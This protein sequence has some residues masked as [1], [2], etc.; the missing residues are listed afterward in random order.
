MRVGGATSQLEYYLSLV[1]ISISFL[2]QS[3]NFSVTLFPCASVL[4]CTRAK[5]FPGPLQSNTASGLVQPSRHHGDGI[6]QS[7]MGG[8]H[9]II[10][11]N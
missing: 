3:N 10:P 9:L 2:S 7:V 8:R 6:V 1:E 5:Q 4:E 11:I